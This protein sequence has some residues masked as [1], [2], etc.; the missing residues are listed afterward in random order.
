MDWSQVQ[1]HARH[2]PKQESVL[3]SLGAGNSKS[4]VT[5]ASPTEKKTAVSSGMRSSASIKTEGSDNSKSF[6][7]PG[8]PAEKKTAVSSGTRS[9]ASIKTEGSDPGIGQLLMRP[10]RTFVNVQ[11]MVDAKDQMFKNQDNTVFELFARVVISSRGNFQKK[12]YFQFRSLLN[13]QLPYVNGTLIHWEVGSPRDIAAQEFL[14]KRTSHPKCFC[15]CQLK[16]EPRLM[17]G[18]VAIV[19]E[20]RRASW[21]EIREVMDMLGR[22]D[23]DK[24]GSLRGNQWGIF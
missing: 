6:V 19:L 24:P 12:Q 4:F 13:E 7:A 20:I 22:K 11:E 14:E 9:S 21:K 18:W 10:Y 5:L 8:S 2:A 16:R 1:E 23:L 17:A 3:H 15:R